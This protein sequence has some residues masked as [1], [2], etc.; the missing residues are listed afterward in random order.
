M[1]I[2]ADIRNAQN[3]VAVRY[4]LLYHRNQTVT[5]NSSGILACLKMYGYIIHFEAIGKNRIATIFLRVSGP[6]SHRRP[7]AEEK[8]IN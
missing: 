3:K 8:K 7:K 2:N 6:P 5:N 1:S 4:V